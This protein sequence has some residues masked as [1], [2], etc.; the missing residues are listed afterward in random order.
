MAPQA[1]Q[2]QRP[3]AK[4]KKRAREDDGAN[5]SSMQPQSHKRRKPSAFDQEDLDLDLEAGL[6]KKLAHLDSMLM[7]DH[8]AQKTRR[9]GSDL[10]P[11]ELSALD[12]SPNAIKDSSSFSEPRTLENLPSFLEAHAPNPKDLADAPKENGSPHTI[13]V[14]G[15]GLRAADIVRAVRK[16]QSKKITV[17]KL[18][19][20]HIKLE[21]S[22]KFLET[23]RTGVS[24]G[25]PVR[26]NDL[27][28]SGALKL[29]KLERL[30]VDASHIDQKKRGIMD[31]KETM[32][33][34]ARWLSRTEFKERYTDPERPLQL[35]FY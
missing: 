34:L 32:I 8:I 33:P 26:L 3:K 29:D 20:K 6:N 7:A 4:P 11:V 23:H 15:A 14:A 19:A 22:K 13:I 18:F 31:M 25:T 24:V 30:V 35:L 28:E 17:G 27:V 1:Q 5:K 2:P 16:Y 10:R 21:D 12:I 9:F